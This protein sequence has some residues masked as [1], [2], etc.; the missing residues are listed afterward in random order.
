MRP[1]VRVQWATLPG[2]TCRPGRS[3]GVSG[4]VQTAPDAGYCGITRR[5]WQSR[6]LPPRCRCDPMVGPAARVAGPATG[7]APWRHGEP[8]PALGRPV[9]H[10]PDQAEAALLTGQPADHLYP[11]ASLAEGALGQV[12]GADALA[13]LGALAAV[14]DD[15]QRQPSP[16]SVRSCRKPR[17]GGGRLGGP[18]PRPRNTACAPS[19]RSPAP[20]ARWSW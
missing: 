9:Q 14:G 11:A 3:G 6:L 15:Q 4:A 12:G 7:A 1:P 13:M 5:W 20:P 16:R 17:Q 8:T 2:V 18:G 19:R 10:R